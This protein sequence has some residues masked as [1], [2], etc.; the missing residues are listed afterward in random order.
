MNNPVWFSWI[1]AG[2]LIGLAMC[3]DEFLI[4]PIAYLLIKLGDKIKG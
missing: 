1:W 3:F 2:V 4:L